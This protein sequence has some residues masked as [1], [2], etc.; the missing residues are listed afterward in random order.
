MA[1]KSKPPLGVMSQKRHIE[2]RWRELVEAVIRY[3]DAEKPVPDIWYQEIAK[4]SKLLCNPHT[5]IAGSTTPAT[6]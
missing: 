3:L 6:L 1:K 5:R 2:L 4:H